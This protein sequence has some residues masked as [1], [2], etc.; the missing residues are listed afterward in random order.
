MKEA[1]NILIKEHMV[2]DPLWNKIWDPSIWPKVS[3]FLW[4]LCH[5][6]ILT[7]DNLRKRNFHGPSICPNCKQ[8]EESIIHLMHHYPL[9]QK[10]WKKISFR[11]QRNGGS[12]EVIRDT[13]RKWAHNPYQS[14]IL[15]FLWKLIRGFVLWA[16]WKERNGRIFKDHT[17]SLEEIWKLL[18]QNIEETIFLKT[19]YQEEFLTIPQEQS[20]WN[21]WNFQQKQ[22][23]LTTGTRQPKNNQPT[24]WTPPPE[25]MF[26]LNFDGASKGNLGNASFGGIFRNH[27]GTPILTF[28]GS[29]GWDTNNSVELEG[30]WQ[31]LLV[32]HDKDLFPL[33]IEGDSQIIIKMVSRILQGSPP[34]KVSD[35]WKIGYELLNAGSIPTEQSL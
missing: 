5:N 26:Q 35:E 34:C 28:L 4:L 31:G 17:R 9:A 18:H 11:C 15:N 16:I 33:I 30:L 8:N 25:N 6:K 21:N 13:V 23:E 7:W 10:I 22:D 14:K 2:I 1:Y 12:N 20:I 24:Q 32:A 3:T 27:K 19:W 29:I